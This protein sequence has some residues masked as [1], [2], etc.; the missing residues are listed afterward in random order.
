[1]KKILLLPVIIAAVSSCA[2][3]FQQI[4]S[5]ASSQMALTDNGY[6]RYNEGDITIEYNFWAENGQV[7][8]NIHNESDKDVYV[9]LERSF[10][11]VNGMTFDYYQNRT[12]STQLSNTIVN[13]STYGV[14][15][16]GTIASSLVSAFA[17]SYGNSASGGSFG[18]YGASSQTRAYSKR[19]TKSSTINRGIEYAEKEG[20]WIPAHSS[21]HFCE[22]SLM[23]APYRRCGFAR[24]PS[25]RE[26]ASVSFTE[27]NSPYVF[28]NMLMLVIE[29]ADHRFSNSF[30]VGGFLNILQKEAYDETKG[31][32]C[33]G[34]KSMDTFWISKY[35]AGNK[36]YIN[37]EF[38]S[39]H[40]DSDRLGKNAIQRTTDSSRRGLFS[41]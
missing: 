33:D 26:E 40:G 29:G 14:S 38:K 1:M 41:R 3:S 31:V 36:F 6:Y 25:K 17:S 22:F 23:D 39:S 30:Y 10:L 37:Y 12:Y 13:S 19:D 5:V 9:D 27:E 28:N 24:N 18:V 4:A 21:R 7:S 16:T 11:V 34:S 15:N 32:K 20:V 8:F 35:K 2:T